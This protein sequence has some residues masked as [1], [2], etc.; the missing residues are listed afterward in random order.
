LK[1]HKFVMRI[2]NGARCM[3]LQCLI[4]VYDKT[5]QKTTFSCEYKVLI[6]C[7]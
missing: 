6:Q 4:I 3:A 2:V 7:P 1:A 5:S